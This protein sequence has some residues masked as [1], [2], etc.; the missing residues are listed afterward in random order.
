MWCA[1]TPSQNVGWIVQPPE[2]RNVAC[3]RVM[4]VDQATSKSRGPSKP[5]PQR[6]YHGIPPPSTALLFVSAPRMATFV[7]LEP[8]STEVSRSGQN[9]VGHRGFCTTGIGVY[10]GT[11]AH[12]V[13]LDCATVSLHLVG[14]V[15]EAPKTVTAG[16]AQ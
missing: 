9:S 8:H 3:A 5:G 16:H 12:V 14:G 2:F 13:P 4:F 11:A 1:C 7:R 15:F 6:Q 10:A